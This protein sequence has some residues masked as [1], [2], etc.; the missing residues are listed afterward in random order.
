MPKYRLNE[1]AKAD[2]LSIARWGDEHYGI[3]R[4]NQYRDELK[5]HFDILAETP[6]LYPAVDH[7]RAGYRRSVCGVHAIYYRIDGD[8]VEIMAVMRAQ[9]TAKHLP[10]E[11]TQ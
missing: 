1:I 8:T 5:A 7:I 4:S 9:D 11:T 6:L 3:E 10:K 2:L